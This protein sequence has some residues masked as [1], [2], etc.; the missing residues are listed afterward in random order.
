MSNTKGQEKEYI[1]KHI[2]IQFHVQQMLV[3][4][5]NIDFQRFNKPKILDLAFRQRCFSFCKIVKSLKAHKE[6]RAS[7]IVAKFDQQLNSP[8]A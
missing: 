6:K 3:K 1:S 8:N 7:K 5:Y 2:P 4:R